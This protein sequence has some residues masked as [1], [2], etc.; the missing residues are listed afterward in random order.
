MLADLVFEPALSA[1]FV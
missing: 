1:N